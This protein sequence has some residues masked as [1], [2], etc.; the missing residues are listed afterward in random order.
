M[1]NFCGYRGGKA[2]LRVAGGWMAV[3]RNGGGRGADCRDRGK[4]ARKD[5][6]FGRG[7]ISTVEDMDCRWKRR[8]GI[9]HLFAH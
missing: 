8:H 6:A 7:R 1:M 4:L 3:R 2:G 9:E 5:P